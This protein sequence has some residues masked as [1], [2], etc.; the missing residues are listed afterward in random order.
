MLDLARASRDIWA[1]WAQA[2]GFPH[3]R[4]VVLIEASEESGSRDL[5]AHIDA[6]AHRIGTPSLIVCLDSGCADYDHLWI[7]TSLRGLLAGELIA[8]Q[9]VHLL[10][11]KFVPIT[12]PKVTVKNT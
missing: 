11:H 6:L 1:G 4:C 2:A 10:Y 8:Q 5:P 7:T 3:A 9:A 12:L